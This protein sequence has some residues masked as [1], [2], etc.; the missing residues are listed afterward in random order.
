MFYKK[1]IDFNFDKRS[2]GKEFLWIKED[3]EKYLLWFRICVFAY[4]FPFVINKMTLIL[5][6][7]K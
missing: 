7:W 4:Y 2:R 3:S 6:K 1:Q 5:E